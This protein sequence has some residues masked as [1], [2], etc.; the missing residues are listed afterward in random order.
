MKPE[1]FGD[2]FVP[3]RV[4]QTA[5]AQRLSKQLMD[6]I[7]GIFMFF[8]AFWHHFLDCRL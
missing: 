6:D 8:L 5:A 1:E 2:A 3:F 4:S 7:G